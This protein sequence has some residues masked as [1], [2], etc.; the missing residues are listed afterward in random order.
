MRAMIFNAFGPPDVLHY[1]DVPDPAP[2][3]GDLLIEVHAV[4]VNR[5]LDVDIRAGRAPH[6][7][8]EP[9]HILGVDP[10]GVVIDVGSDVQGFAAGD[11]VSVTMGMPGGGR[12]G[13]ECNGGDAQLTIAPAA[14]CVKVRDEIGF[15]DATVISRHGPVAYNLLFNMGKLEAGQT[16]LIMGAAGNLGSIGIQLAKAAGATVIAAAGSRARADVGASLGADHTVDYNAVNLKDAVMDITDG[17]GVDLFYDNIANP[18]ICPLGIE[19]LKVLGRMVTAGSHGGPVV[20]VDFSTVYHKQLTIMGNPRSKA[21]DALPCFD[22]AAAGNLKVVI[23]RVVPLSA[24]PEM[25]ALIEADPGI[26]KV[27]LDPTLG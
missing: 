2:G 25:H 1:E 13:L 21:Q 24:A 4:S 18:D 14:S 23:D 12:Y 27:I 22:A 20:P 11:R 5:V 8:V 26:G 3:P 19:S 15:A 7:G 9:P 6:Y 10:S 17:A 16:V